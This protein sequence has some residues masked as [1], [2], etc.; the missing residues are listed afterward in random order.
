MYILVY[1]YFSSLA[2]RCP[3]FVTDRTMAPKPISRPKII[4]KKTNKFKRF[5][6]DRY[7]RVKVRLFGGEASISMCWGSALAFLTFGKGAVWKISAHY[8]R[9]PIRPSL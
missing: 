5:H 8:A 1:M 7:D 9:H 2:Y 6:S 3:N 4:K